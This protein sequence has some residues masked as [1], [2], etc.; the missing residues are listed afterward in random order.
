MGFTGLPGGNAPVALGSAAC[1]GVGDFSGGMGVKHAGGSLHAALRVVIL[2]HLTSFS[3]LI[4]LACALGG[5]FPRGHLLGWGL[6]AG[7]L[8]GFS[9]SAFYTALSRGTMGVSAAVSGLL[10]AAIPAVVSSVVD[11]TP[12][13]IRILGFVAAGAAIWLIAAGESAHEQRATTLLATLAGVGF[14]LYF[15]C[16]RFA[17]PAGVLWPM[18]T[19]RMGSIGTCTLLLLFLPKAGE[20]APAVI[21]RSVIRW[22]LLTALFDTCGN[23]LFV[24][25]TRSGR[26]DVAS[27]LASLY[28]ASTIVLAAVLLHERLS[29]RQRC[30]LGVALAAVLLVTL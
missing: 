22:V 19:A 8:A 12:G 20:D 4:L 6:T 14:G 13:L 26:L 2:S 5:P 9:L 18:T 23:L 27:V 1:W 7:V 29:V 25:A 30:G 15:V 11:G 28:P 16:L 10:A 17:G 21:N 3:V 24:E